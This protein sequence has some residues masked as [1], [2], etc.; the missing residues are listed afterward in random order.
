[1]RK[2]SAHKVPRELVDASLEGPG[3]MS[4]FMGQWQDIL[5]TCFLVNATRPKIHAFI[6]ISVESRSFYSKSLPAALWGLQGCIVDY[7]CIHTL[8]E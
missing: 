3:G 8:N 2:Y 4:E 7:R 5:K 1:M 6:Q